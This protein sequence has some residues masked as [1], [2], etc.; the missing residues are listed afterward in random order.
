MP[1]HGLERILPTMTTTTKGE[2]R[3]PQFYFTILTDTGHHQSNLDEEIAI[4]N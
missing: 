3:L 1:I 2:P 4:L